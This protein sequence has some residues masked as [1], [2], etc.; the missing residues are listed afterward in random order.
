MIAPDLSVLDLSVVQ[1][2]LLPRPDV[3]E[4][5][6]LSDFESRAEVGPEALPSILFHTFANTFQSLNCCAFSPDSQSL[7]GIF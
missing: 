5:A 2:P 6:V 3:L 4:P 1:I 7:A